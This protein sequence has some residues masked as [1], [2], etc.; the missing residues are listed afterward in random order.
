MIKVEEQELKSIR[1][2]RGQYQQI[3]LQLGQAEL[4]INDLDDAL[5][6]VEDAKKSLLN[7]YSEIK[8]AE[9]TK[10]DELNKKYGAG[11]LNIESGVLTP[12]PNQ[13]QNPQEPVQ[14]SR[15]EDVPAPPAK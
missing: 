10:M 8:D 12:F 7:R 1:D 14:T 3:M 11:N 4:Q 9:R 6:Q 2:I 13:E 5:R 15:V